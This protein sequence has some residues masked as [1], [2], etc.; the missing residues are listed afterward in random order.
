MN[1][2]QEMTLDQFIRSKWFIAT[3]RAMAIVGG[4]SITLGGGFVTWAVF[5]T[6]AQSAAAVSAVSRVELVQEQRA[7]KADSF[8]SAITKRVDRVEDKLDA[9]N[10]ALGEIRGIVSELA[11]NDAQ[12]A[13]WLARS[14]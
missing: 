6:K 1:E 9:A 3:A 11:R 8:Q 7:D 4:T 2:A 14:P 12:D 13:R 5:D 10:M